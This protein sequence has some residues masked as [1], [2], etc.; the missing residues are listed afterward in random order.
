MNNTTIDINCDMGE[1]F[2]DDAAL[3]PYISSANIACGAH[4]GNEQTMV[5]TILLCVQHDVA[6]GAHPSFEDRPNFGRTEMQLGDEKLYDLISRQLELFAS[7]ALRCGATIHHVKPH[8]ALYNMAARNPAMAG[9]VAKAVHSFDGGLILYGLAGSCSI[10]EAKNIGLSTMSEVF[11]DRSYQPSGQLTP[12]SQPN[13]LIHSDEEALAQVLQMVQTQTVRVTDN[14]IVPILAETICIHG[15]GV[16]A[17]A[18]AK[19]I[20]NTLN[21]KNISVR[22]V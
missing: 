3:V 19:K 16:H 8:G 5:D 21:E 4:A 6:V 7:V 22:A 9:V 12:R 10:A 13:A 2:P 17:V 15:D 20:Y 18:F 1:G 14:S 11:A